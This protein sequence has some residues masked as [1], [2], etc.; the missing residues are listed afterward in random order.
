M[1]P[2]DLKIGRGCEIERTNRI[3]LADL[4]RMTVKC[5]GKR[6]TDS[7]ADCGLE[8]TFD[9]TQDL[10]WTDVQGQY[11][12]CPSCGTSFKHAREIQRAFA[13]LKSM[14]ADRLSF[15]LEK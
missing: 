3:S 11:P 15:T 1:T 2:P 14:G 8:L 6:P 13:D 4:T 9:L 12:K 10:D 7:T 5:Y